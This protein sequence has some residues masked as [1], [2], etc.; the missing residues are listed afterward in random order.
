MDFSV[1]VGCLASTFLMNPGEVGFAELIAC[2]ISLLLHIVN[3]IG[4]VADAKIV[5]RKSFIHFA[6]TVKI[7]WNTIII[8]HCFIAS[9]RI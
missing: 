2:F 4:S 3:P 8:K 1:L 5:R 6:M 9:M 7:G